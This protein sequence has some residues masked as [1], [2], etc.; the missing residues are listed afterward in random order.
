MRGKSWVKAF[1]IQTNLSRKQEAVN[2]VVV[3]GYIGADVA[4]RLDISTRAFTAG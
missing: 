3:N 4:A 2:Q 1:V